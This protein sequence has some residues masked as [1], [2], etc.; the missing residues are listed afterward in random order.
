MAQL[1]RNGDARLP[2]IGEGIQNADRIV[3]GPES[4]M[5]ITCDDSMRVVIAGGTDIDLGTLTGARESESYAAYLLRGLAGF[6]LPIIGTRRFE[7]RTP[8]AVA[9]VRSTE[10]LVEVADDA[11]A[12]FVREGLVSVV[13]AQGG[14]LLEAGD[15][16]DV[17]AAGIAGPVKEWGAARRDAIAARLGA[18]W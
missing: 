3:T 6:I 16:I 9:S 8:S 15:G 18:N 13:A 7:V 17:T 1:V 11:T 12:V 10:W 5:T 14:G 2:R 4:R